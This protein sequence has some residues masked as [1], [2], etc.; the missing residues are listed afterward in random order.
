MSTKSFRRT[1]YIRIDPAGRGLGQSRPLL[2]PL[3]PKVTRVDI[4]M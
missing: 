3:G 1:Q 2:A 4:T